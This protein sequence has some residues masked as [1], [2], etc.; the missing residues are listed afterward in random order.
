VFRKQKTETKLKAMKKENN[1]RKT[2][3]LKTEWIHDFKVNNGED[4]LSKNF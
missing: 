3:N 4:R 1:A 2:E